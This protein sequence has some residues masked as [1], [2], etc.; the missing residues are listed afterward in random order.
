MLDRR[1][2]RSVCRIPWMRV[3]SKLCC[4]MAAEII[5]FNN[6]PFRDQGDNICNGDVYVR[7]SISGAT[8]FGNLSKR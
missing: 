2:T 3:N 8:K 5:K 4:L 6:T 7:L 1:R